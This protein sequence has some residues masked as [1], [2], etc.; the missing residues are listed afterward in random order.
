MFYVPTGLRRRKIVDFKVFVYLEYCLLLKFNAKEFLKSKRNEKTTD[1]D[2]DEDV[3][4]LH[5]VIT[6]SRN[7]MNN[8]V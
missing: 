1:E 6:K 2:E 7:K 3:S 5:N 4:T 8:R